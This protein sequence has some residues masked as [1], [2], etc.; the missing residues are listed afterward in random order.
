M[1]VQTQNDFN[2]LSIHH[3]FRLVRF[4]IRADVTSKTSEQQWFK[5]DLDSVGVIVCEDL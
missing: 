4:L 5:V 3:Q 1:T 2:S